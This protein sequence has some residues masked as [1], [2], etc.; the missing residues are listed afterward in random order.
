MAII[1]R[2][3]SK[4][5]SYYAA[6][7]VLTIMITNAILSGIADTVAQSLTSLRT[8]RVRNPSAI[9]PS[10]SR[11]EGEIHE[12]DEKNPFKVGDT[13]LIHESSNGPPPFDFERLV[14]FMA[15]SFIM[16]PVQYHWFALLGRTFP[17]AKG[18][19]G[20]GQVLKRTALDQ[21]V[22]APAGLSCFFTFM[23]LAEGGGKKEIKN[24]FQ[25]AYLPA[26]KANWI[27]WPAVQIV[28]FR[29]MPL[30]FQIPF[31]STIGIAWTAYL[32]LT[33]A[34]TNERKEPQAIAI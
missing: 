8:S 30:Q 24:K 15:Y 21:S 26:L 33:N 31:V 1:G 23:T 34:A 3:I 10:I 12:L 11:I 22:M 7:P 6:K 14:R 5:N 2:M 28:N 32:S 25:T 9:P 16:S 19:V 27:V 17:I 13:D 18:T 29:F 4:F 20:V